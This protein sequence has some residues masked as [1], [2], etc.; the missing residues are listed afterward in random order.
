MKIHTRK[1]AK[2]AA[3]NLG[4]VDGVVVNGGGP[5]NKIGRAHV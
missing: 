2:E 1:S 5:V 4:Q 3:T